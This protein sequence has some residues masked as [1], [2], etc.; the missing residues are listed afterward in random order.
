MTIPFLMVK[1]YYVI[2]ISLSE[3][4]VC[5]IY[6][7]GRLAI[8]C[9]TIALSFISLT[10]TGYNVNVPDPEEQRKSPQNTKNV[11]RFWLTSIPFHF[12]CVLFRVGCLAYFCANLSYWTTVIILFTMLVNMLILHY[13]MYT[14]YI[15]IKLQ[16][17]QFQHSIFFV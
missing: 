13:G 11:K 2:L 6:F 14:Y 3:I 7:S 10:K 12:V 16:I 8:L 9:I 4:F 17:I 1:Y 15:S 5:Q